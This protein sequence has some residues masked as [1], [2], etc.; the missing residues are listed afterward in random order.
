MSSSVYS[1]ESPLRFK[2]EFQSLVH[3]HL[4]KVDHSTKIHEPKKGPWEL[5]GN[6]RKIRDQWSNPNILYTCVKLS[7]PT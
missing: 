2:A 5:N 7:K 4:V 1:L 6:E 3:T